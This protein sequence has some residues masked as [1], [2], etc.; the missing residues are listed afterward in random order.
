MKQRLSSLQ[1]IRAIA[2]IL[3]F[4]SHVELISTGP[5]GVSLFLV[6]SGFC[7]TYAYLDR[8]D[9]T[10]KAGFVNNIKFAYGKVKKL[11]PLHVVTLLFVAL[12]IFGGLI[13]HKAPEKEIAE[14]GAYFA[15][16]GLLLQ[17]WIPW[18]DGYF[19][20]NAV[21]W[22]LST[23]AFS[24]FLF[25][26]V[27]REIQ[28]KDKKRIIRL[29]AI[30]LGLMVG[31]AIILGMGHRNLGWTNALLKWVVYICP[32]YRTGDFIIGLVAGYMYI[33]MYNTQN[34]WGEVWHT[35]AEIVIMVLMTIQV[36]IYSS[37]T[38][39]AINWMLTL[40]WLPT[41]IFCVYLFAENKGAVSRVLSKNKVLIWIGNISGEAFLIHQICIKAAEYITKDKWIV[42]VIAFSAT[43]ICTV[44][45]RWIEQRTSK[46]NDWLKTQF[47]HSD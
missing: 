36:M 44:I 9:K 4:L 20:F 33:C 31:I 2:F 37:G 3:I 41:S 45:W 38:V 7:M 42:A 12:I 35:A 47:S 10:P 13:L 27:F 23:T 15:A 29:T 18:R 28:S 34:L 17:S 14:Q 32:L 30:A 26:W 19:S 21:S 8:P 11:Y 39:H 1:V 5:I 25:P 16:N 24:Y 43:L 22:Y 6:L 40:F 46:C